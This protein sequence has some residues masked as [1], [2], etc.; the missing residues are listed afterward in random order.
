M[1]SSWTRLRSASTNRSS[2]PLRWPC[3][4]GPSSIACGAA[5]RRG[6][7]TGRI[8]KILRQV[9]YNGLVS[10]VYEGARDMDPMHAVPVGAK[11]LRGYLARSMS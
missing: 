8:F 11:F 4:C 1:L 9:K 10:L 7:I 5:R 3:S 6:S 2:A